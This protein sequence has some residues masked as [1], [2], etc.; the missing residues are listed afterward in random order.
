MKTQNTAN[1]NKRRKKL[2]H[3][4]SKTEIQF[5]KCDLSYLNSL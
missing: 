4:Y 5:V 3:G 1:K 2:S